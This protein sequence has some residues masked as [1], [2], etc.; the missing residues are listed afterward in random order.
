MNS[1][2]YIPHLCA[3]SSS[4]IV[5]F[6]FTFMS[7]GF[8]VYGEDVPWGLEVDQL[9]R[10]LFEQNDL[11]SGENGANREKTNFS[12]GYLYFR[13]YILSARV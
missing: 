12:A 13:G 7:R 4:K 8:C 11:H 2:A 9:F 3:H 6:S 1:T 5:E 10:I